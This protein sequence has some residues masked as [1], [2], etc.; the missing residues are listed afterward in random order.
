MSL[1]TWL[2]DRTRGFAGQRRRAHSSP[3]RRTTFRPQLEALEGRTLPSTYY[4]ATAADLIADINAANRHG[5]TNT[6]VLTAPTTSPYVLTAV[7]NTTDGAT[8][9]PV[10]A[11][12]K[13]LPDDLTIIGNGD[14]IERSTAS[15]TP[16]FRLFDVASGA[17]LTL[18]NVTL[19]NG[20]ALGSGVSAEGG[21]IYNQGTLALSQVMIQE[22]NAS[23]VAGYAGAGGGIWSN[24]PLTLHNSAILAN[25]ATGDLNGN[26]GNA[27]GGGIYMAGGTADITGT[28][29][30]NANGSGGNT[31]RGGYN[32]SS[33]YGGGSAYG[34]AVYVAGGTVTLSG[35][36][37]GL[38]NFGGSPV[39]VAEAGN[40]GVARGGAIC[41][42]GGSVTLT[43]D[44]V[45][46]NL[47]ESPQ[48]LVYPQGGGIFIASGATVYLDSFTVNNTFGNTPDN[49]H[50]TYN[51]LP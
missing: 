49:I 42:A 24:G 31:A 51:L 20:F 7:N 30:G 13:K 36:T 10:I 34:G 48:S 17:S 21:A 38:A 14:T 23:G 25:S 5:G 46:S 26:G 11:G 27:Y 44:Y 33:P 15:G 29:F 43:N 45:Q 22:N 28:A 12:P 41:V 40:G 39:N 37:F 35:D 16:A 4:A 9:T 8:G 50:G 1:F 2:Q 32:A 3:R 6:I 19:Q 18:E 47:A